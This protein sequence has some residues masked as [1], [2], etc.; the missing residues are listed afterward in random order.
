GAAAPAIMGP[1]AVRGGARPLGEVRAPLDE[2]SNT[3]VNTPRLE[4]KSQELE[5]AT[6]EL[7]AAN[8]RLTELD[9][10]KDEF[11]STVSH[12]LRTPLTS[13]RAF[14]EILH[15]HPALPQPERERFLG[16][17]I[18]ET[19]R[20]TRL[21]NQ[22]LDLSRIESGRVE[23]RESLVDLRGVIEDTITAN[24]QLFRE[25]GAHLEA[26]LPARV[27]RVLADL[28]RIVQVLVNL[29][30]NAAKFVERGRGR[31]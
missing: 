11:V 27:P 25:R 30:S 2:A 19:A 16:I 28:D 13:I 8:E 24:S 3:T 5:R 14:T 20:L 1:W 9:R 15:D 4:Q 12:E 29:L 17:I 31:V 6:R 22:I 7:R 10:M 21:I 26:R 18:K 23:W